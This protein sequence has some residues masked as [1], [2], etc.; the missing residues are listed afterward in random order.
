ML[1][2][3]DSNTAAN[4]EIS[5]CGR[6]ALNEAQ[7]NEHLMH[8]I[9]ALSTLGHKKSAAIRIEMQ[10]IEKYQVNTHD[11]FSKCLGR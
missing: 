6:S 3:T 4:K 10:K 1:D 9:C 2:P 8:T 5:F 7:S 11:V